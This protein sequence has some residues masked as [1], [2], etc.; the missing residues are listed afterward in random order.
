MK[1]M[2]VLSAFLIV[3]IL[4]QF[5]WINTSSAAASVTIEMY[6][7]HKDMSC[8]ISPK[9]KIINTGTTDITL[10]T[11]KV[12]YYYTVDDAIGMG[13]SCDYAT[14]GS[15]L[16]KGTFVK[17][18]S[19]A[20]T[21]NYYL[22]ISFLTT[23]AVLSAGSSTEVASRFWRTDWLLFNQS[24]D[25]SY[26]STATNYAISNNTSAYISNT[27]IWGSEPVVGTA[28]PTTKPT[29]TAT[30]KPTS[31]PTTKPSNTATTKPTSTPTTKPSNTATTKPTSTPTTKPSNT[32]TIKPT[33]TPTTKPSNTATTKPTSTP[34]TKPT[35]KPTSTS[36]TKPTS[37]PTTK[38]TMPSASPTAYK[39]AVNPGRTEAEM[40]AKWALYSPK[41]TG[42]G[43]AEAPS[44]TEPYKSGSL[45]SGFIQDGLNMLNFVRYTVGYED[46]IVADPSLN[47][48]CQYGSVLN[49][50]VSDP[51][52]TNPHAPARPAGMVGKPEYDAFYNLG[53]AACGQSNIM[54]ASNMGGTLW[55]DV[56]EWMNDRGVTSLGH[57]TATLWPFAGKTGFGMAGEWSS[58]YVYDSSHPRTPYGCMTW[59]SNGCFPVRFFNGSLIWSAEFFSSKLATLDTNLINIKITR[60]SDGT[61]WNIKSGSSDGSMSVYGSNLLKFTF[62]PGEYSAGTQYDVHITG[63]TLDDSSMGELDYSVK[64]I[65]IN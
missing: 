22:E 33:S 15:S 13:F 19:A 61:V 41:Y 45:N 30:T 16:V 20:S 44:F 24:N 25:F 21:A 37:T 46:D 3:C 56:Q 8:N 50:L 62:N 28:T 63:I 4:C 43:Y 59:P 34:T 9:F 23:G 38:P 6:N 18:S 57:R 60:K 5:M 39:F 40:N 26:N 55:W 51:Y 64:L 7:V 48:N 12:R 52:S 2:R 53:S 42:G 58:M 31:T 10:D 27:K 36:T 49:E 35:T 29:S 14:V 54:W 32:A 47:Q 65:N 1:R 11:L 17:M